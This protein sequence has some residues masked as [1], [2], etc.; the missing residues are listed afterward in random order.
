MKYTRIKYIIIFYLFSCSNHHA[1]NDVDKSTKDSNNLKSTET[2]TLTTHIVVVKCDGSDVPL[3][4]RIP[5]EKEL[6]LAQQGTQEARA[7]NEELIIDKLHNG[8]FIRLLKADTL[9]YHYVQVVDQMNNSELQQQRN[10]RGF[11]IS[12]YCNNPTLRKIETTNML[13]IDQSDEI[14]HINEFLDN[15]KFN[16]DL[17]DYAFAFIT[18]EADLIQT[19]SFS[20]YGINTIKFKIS[21]ISLQEYRLLF[22]GDAEII[23]KYKNTK[24][25]TFSRYIASPFMGN[26]F[27]IHI[28]EGGSLA[29]LKFK[30]PIDDEINPRPEEDMMNRIK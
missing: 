4:N 29:F 5:T 30:Q 15:H 13:T 24:G 9:G 11:I 12:Q 17:L 2:E 14:K 7:L 23:N 19:F 28:K 27:E 18:H 1:T 8:Q 10:K 26:D 22:N 6:E 25:E 16:N 21:V 20:I 3:W